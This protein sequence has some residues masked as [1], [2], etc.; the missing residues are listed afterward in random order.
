MNKQPVGV[1]GS[2][3]FGMA[4]ANLLSENVDVLMYA[5]R[6][7]V[8]QQIERREGRYKP[9]ASNITAISDLKQVAEKCTLIFPIVPSKAF[10]SM[11][12]NLGKYLR[13]YHILIHG[14]KGLDLSLRPE[15]QPIL[16]KYIKTMSQVMEEESVVCRVGCLSG[17]NLSSEIME[18]QPA[19]TLIASKYNEVIRAGQSALR[20]HRFQVYGT[21]DILGAELAG[22]LKNVIALASGILGGRGL[23]KNVWALLIT[24]GLSEM[25]HI[26]K[27]MGSSV[28][29]F[30][31]VAGIGDLVATAASNKSRN[32]TVGY[33]LAKGETLEQILEDMTEVAEG[34]RTLETVKALIQH[35]NI[36]AP[37]TEVV[38]RVFFKGMDIDRAI[39]FLMTY[40]YAVDVDY[41]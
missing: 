37:I 14:T 36:S 18:G 29:S 6:E 7:E 30:L 9:L 24:R 40:P 17:P 8:R 41:L 32:Y 5:R 2:G 23:G 3:S 12:Q 1:I 19:A 33:R 11:M 10:R 39:H 16:P 22:A 26:S 13:P 15:G 25:V 4:I 31:G 21:H 38:H 35:F 27:A 20:S 28:E 34:I